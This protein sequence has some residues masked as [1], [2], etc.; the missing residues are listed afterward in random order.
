MKYKP[1]SVKRRSGLPANYSGNAQELYDDGGICLLLPACPVRWWIFLQSL[2]G[3]Q[4]VHV[5]FPF[6]FRLAAQVLRNVCDYDVG[7]GQQGSLQMKRRL[8]VQEILPPVG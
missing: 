7:A 5:L 2:S 3:L 8:V 4:I 6:L 1:K